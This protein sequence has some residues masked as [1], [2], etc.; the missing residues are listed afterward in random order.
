M[1]AELAAWWAVTLAWTRRQNV[2]FEPF[3]PCADDRARERDLCEI[4]IATGRIFKCDRED[5][6]KVSHVRP[7]RRR[8]ASSIATLCDSLALHVHGRILFLKHLSHESV[9]HICTN[10]LVHP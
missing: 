5:L 2:P 4:I 3:L 9:I 6:I 7:K 10:D 1:K 8:T